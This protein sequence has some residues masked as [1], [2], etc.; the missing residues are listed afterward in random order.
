MISLPPLCSTF[1]FLITNENTVHVYCRRNLWLNNIV[2]RDEMWLN[3][4]ILKITN[5]GMDWNTRELYL[6]QIHQ[7]NLRFLGWQNTFIREWLVSKFYNN[8]IFLILLHNPFALPGRLPSSVSHSRT[9][10]V[11]RGQWR[12]SLSA[13]THEP[14]QAPTSI[15]LPGFEPR[16]SATQDS[17]ADLHTTAGGQQFSLAYKS[18]GPLSSPFFYIF[19]FKNTNSVVHLNFIFL[20]DR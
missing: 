14:W 10:G 4:D 15:P 11:A 2:V 8:S 13:A 18:T 6:K 3:S 7:E 20:S 16:T 1:V 19:H 5:T 12:D 9:F 17:D